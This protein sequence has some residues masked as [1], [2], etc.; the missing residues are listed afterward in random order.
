MSDYNH[1]MKRIKDLYPEESKKKQ[2]EAEGQNEGGL[3][4]EETNQEETG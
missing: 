2:Q 1:L 3:D 4:N